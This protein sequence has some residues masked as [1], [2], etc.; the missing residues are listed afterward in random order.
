MYWIQ[1]PGIETPRIPLYNLVL[2]ANISILLKKKALTDQDCFRLALQFREKRKGTFKPGM[3][4]HS[5][6]RASPIS[7]LL[8]VLKQS[9]IIKTLLNH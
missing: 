4:A 2:P 1:D 5:A 3:K 7:C 9:K 8:P 6:K